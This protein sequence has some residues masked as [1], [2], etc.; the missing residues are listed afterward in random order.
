MLLDIVYYVNL[1]TAKITYIKLNIPLRW[2]E[3]QINNCIHYEI[4]NYS[5][6]TIPCDLIEIHNTYYEDYDQH[7]Q[8]YL[9]KKQRKWTYPKIEHGLTN[10]NIEFTLKPYETHWN[11]AVIQIYRYV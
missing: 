10:K 11:H 5:Y 2:Q 9:D 7:F 4:S 1:Q 6:N 3:H 8:A